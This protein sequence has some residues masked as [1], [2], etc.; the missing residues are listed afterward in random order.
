MKRI[1]RKS[2]YALFRD[3]FTSDSKVALID[4]YGSYTQK[5]SFDI[6]CGLMNELSRFG[7]KRN[8][9]V[10]LSSAS[11]K[12]TALIIAAIIGLG[13]IAFLYIRVALYSRS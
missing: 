10:V 1:T 5:E 2:Y 6:L 7:V 9:V 3:I 8:D 11:R 12:E 13:A 4:K